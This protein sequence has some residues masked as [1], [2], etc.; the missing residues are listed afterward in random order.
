[1]RRGSLSTPS[2][3]CCTRMCALVGRQSSFRRRVLR[4]ARAV[5]WLLPL[6]MKKPKDEPLR[7]FARGFSCLS[8]ALVGRAS[9]QKCRRKERGSHTGGVRG[10]KTS[11][12]LPCAHTHAHFDIHTHVYKCNHVINTAHTLRPFALL[13]K[14]RRA[15]GVAS[16][17]KCYKRCIKD[18]LPAQNKLV[19]RVQGFLLLP[20]RVLFLK[21]ACATKL[22]SPT[23]RRSPVILLLSRRK[24]IDAKEAD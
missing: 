21:Q 20:R 11:H 3:R 8:A 10:N 13:E 7:A 17:R 24:R 9:F 2:K 23:E 14:Q 5:S 16:K 1:M 18:R 19:R 4:S 6:Q 22:S 12:R 15:S